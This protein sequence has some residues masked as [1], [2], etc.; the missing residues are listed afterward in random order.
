MALPKIIAYLVTLAFCLTATGLL[1]GLGT[2]LK[3]STTWDEK[4]KGIS[5]SLAVFTCLTCCMYKV[6]G[7]IP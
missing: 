7:Y 4:K 3:K 2:E 1:I 5:I 6:V